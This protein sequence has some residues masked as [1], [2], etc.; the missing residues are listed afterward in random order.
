MDGSNQIPWNAFNNPPGYLSEHIAPCPVPPLMP[1]G[2]PTAEYITPS[3]MPP[4]MPHPPMFHPVLLEKER[5]MYNAEMH[6]ILDENKRLVEERIIS[7]HELGVAGE[8]IQRLNLIIADIHVQHEIHTHKLMERGLKLIEEIP[9]I[10]PLKNEIKHLHSEV[11]R[12]STIKDDLSSQVETLTENLARVQVENNQIPSLRAEIDGLRH[13]LLCARSV[14][15]YENKA[16]VELMDQLETNKTGLEKLSAIEQSSID[17]FCRVLDVI[18]DIQSASDKIVAFCTE[19]LQ[20]LDYGLVHC[21]ALF[22]APTRERALQIEKVMLALGNHLGVKIHVCVDGTSI[23]EEK[24]VL[25]VGVHLVVGTPWRVLDML[26][27]QNQYICPDH[28]RMFVLDE[29]EEMLSGGLI[30]QTC[31]VFHLLPEKVQIV[32]LYAT[33]PKDPLEI[34]KKFMN[35]PVR[36]FHGFNELT[37]EGIKQF[38][39]NVVKE[40]RKLGA[41]FHLYERL[42]ITHSVVIFVN[43]SMKV[44]LLADKMRNRGHTVS[45]THEK[46]DEK[47]RDTIMRDFCSGSSRLLITT[48][49]SGRIVEAQQEIIVVNYDLPTQLK[50]Y[51]RRIG[52][53]S[54]QF[55]SKKQAINFVTTEDERILCEIKRFY[56]VTIDE[57]PSNVVDF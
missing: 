39:V 45:A 2:Y 51:L 17:P 5:E 25:S 55:E 52:R 9:A 28:I 7:Q 3:P 11:I 56:N 53:S 24:H 41:L 23:E 20:Q 27:R 40:E 30:D 35:K 46:M 36:I 32:A 47:T 16:K 57:L 48:D 42:L 19:I 37:L 49:F 22:L 43:D 21:Q 18:R 12:L 44:N 38:Y 50:N 15:E 14:A 8:K 29:A 13:E 26:Q 34:T 1:P 33:M 31:D 54:E 10:E 6:R 4:P